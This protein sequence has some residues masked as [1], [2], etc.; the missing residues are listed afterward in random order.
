MMQN[1]LRFLK[2]AMPFLAVL[3]LW[4]LQSP[5]WNP[6]GLLAL[7]PIFYC[8]F[9]R[10][11][12]WFVPFAVVFCFLIDYRGDTVLYWTSVYCLCYAVYGFQSFIDLTRADD[13]GFQ[14]FAAFW[15]ATLLLLAITHLQWWVVLRTL[16]LLVWGLALYLPI[17]K[18]IERVSDD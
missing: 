14:A 11:T 9:I 16:W 10:P 13:S 2:I 4:R 1:I 18:L 8:T 15:S 6:V 3:F 12:P 17:V 7:I 5:F